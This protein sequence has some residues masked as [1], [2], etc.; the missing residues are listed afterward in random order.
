MSFMRKL[1]N[2]RLNWLKTWDC[3]D[4]SRTQTTSRT[5]ESSFFK[6]YIHE[7]F[8]IF[9]FVFSSSFRNFS[10]KRQF[11]INCG[12]YAKID[13]VPNYWLKVVF[14]TFFKTQPLRSLQL[15]SAPCTASFIKNIVFLLIMG[16]IR[17]LLFFRRKFNIFFKNHKIW[18]SWKLHYCL[19]I[20]RRKVSSWIPCFLKCPVD[21]KMS[22]SS[23]KD[24][25]RKKAHFFSKPIP[26]RT[27]RSSLLPSVEFIFALNGFVKE[28]IA[29]NT[30]QYFNT[31]EV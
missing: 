15:H 8:K 4:F 9:T 1:R 7:N 28:K 21:K 31:I 20:D 12:F 29:N 16:L 10:L 14:C 27:P 18:K 23:Q 3:P 22:I 6:C 2:F 19:Q 24:W 5:L 11:F 30:I 25:K 26:S 13:S 17:K